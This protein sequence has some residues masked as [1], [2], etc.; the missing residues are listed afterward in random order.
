MTKKKT[1]K[2]K[3]RNGKKNKGRLRPRILLADDAPA[4]SSQAD[5]R[6]TALLAISGKLAER[7][8]AEIDRVH[9]EDNTFSPVRS[10][11]FAKIFELYA[12]ERSAKLENG[13]STVT[14]PSRSLLLTGSPAAKLLSLAGKRGAYELMVLGT[15]GR[16]GMSR[17]LTGS[18]AEELIR[19]ARIPVL[20]VGPAALENLSSILSGLS[21]PTLKIFV[22]TGLTK[23]SERAEDYAARL[24]KKTGGELVFF[25]SL[26][27]GLHPAIQS[28]F[29]LPDPGAD[30]AGLIHDMKQNA[31]KA[32]T[33]KTEA[34]R[35]KGIQASSILE[36][37]YHSAEDSILRE[38]RNT[39]A[40]LVVMGTHGR[41]LLPGAFFGRTARGVIRGA[42]VPVITVRS[43]SA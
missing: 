17:L 16:T 5:F 39:G 18:V 14:A 8:G 23:N 27:D 22:P 24:A 34:F 31:Q 9:V 19:H 40:S 13:A 6:A 7:L 1:T 28:V 33:K 43:V 29:A 35:K 10:A 15:Q 2:T 37:G 32:L 38:V 21:E 4:G 11:Q 25:Y 41:S 20:T 30:L 12:R 26:Y 36:H 3:S 42:E